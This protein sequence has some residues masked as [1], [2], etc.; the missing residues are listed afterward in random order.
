MGFRLNMET[1]AGSNIDI[2]KIRRENYSIKDL[3]PISLLFVRFPFMCKFIVLLKS[4][5]KVRLK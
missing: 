2:S 3:N 5:V 4:L 1:M